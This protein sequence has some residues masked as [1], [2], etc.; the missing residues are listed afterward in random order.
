MNSPE[1]NEL[2][3]LLQ[4]VRSWPPSIRIVLARQILETLESPPV[5]TVPLSNWSKGPSATEIA[6]LFKIDKPAPDDATV[7]Q[8]IDDYRM[9][10]YGK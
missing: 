6:T 3:E 4:R 7:E 2:T 8:W 10:K 9:E 1:K 5:P